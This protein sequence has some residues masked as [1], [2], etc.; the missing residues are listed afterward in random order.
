MVHVLDSVMLLPKAG[1]EKEGTGP[2]KL[3]SKACR[4]MSILEALSHVPSLSRTMRLVQNGDV[5][6]LLRTSVP[7]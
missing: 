4:D 3:T 2:L 7:F 5:S 1:Q 6:Q